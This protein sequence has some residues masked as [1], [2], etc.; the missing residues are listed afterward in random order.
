MQTKTSMLNRAKEVE[1]Q[2]K[3][4]YKDG[5]MEKFTHMKYFSNIGLEHVQGYTQYEHEGKTYYIF[6]HDTTGDYGYVIVT[7]S[8]DASSEKVW[9][10]PKGDNHP[11]GIQCVGQYLFV[12]CEKDNYSNIHIIDLL[13][14]EFVH[15]IKFEHRA[16]CLGITDY[17]INGQQYYIMVIGEKT[18][19]HVYRALID[20]SVKN[21]IAN[22]HFNK[23]GTFTLEDVNFIEIQDN[24]HEKNHKHDIDCQGMGLITEADSNKV[25]MLAPVKEKTSEDWIYLME[26]NIANESSVSINCR[27]CRHIRSKGGIGGVDGIHFR[28]GAGIRITSGS[29]LVVLATARNII[30]MGYTSLDTNYWV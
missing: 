30:S 23:V 5:N 18:T 4:L 17:Q 28:Y 25:Y 16:G 29:K 7:T 13:T 19:Y 11:G 9:Q 8:F 21:N 3:D 15:T 22:A 14:G 27:Y 2:F 26:I 10:L 12:P 24:G 20:E 1:K 6:T